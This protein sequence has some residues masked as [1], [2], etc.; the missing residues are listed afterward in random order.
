MSY[1]CHKEKKNPFEMRN[2]GGAQ[3]WSVRTWWYNNVTLWVT[4]WLAWNADWERDTMV[5]GGRLTSP[6]PAGA[7][8]PVQLCLSACPPSEAGRMTSGCLW[9][10][11]AGT[12]T[13]E[14][15]MRPQLEF[16]WRWCWV[17]NCV[18]LFSCTVKSKWQHQ[19]FPICFWGHAE[20]P[21][22]Q[23]PHQSPILTKHRLYHQD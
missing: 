19:N 11:C 10:G 8:V 9:A 15:T 16:S 3:D 23:Y 7:A 5:W 6:F 17:Q 21:G 18:Y 22:T 14:A 12:R 4:L 1:I 13:N 2:K 20:V